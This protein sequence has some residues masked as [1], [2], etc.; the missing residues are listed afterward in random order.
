M[1]RE[2]KGIGT[3]GIVAIIAI[4]VILAGFFY[5]VWSTKENKK[6]ISKENYRETNTERNLNFEK[7]FEDSNGNTEKGRNR[8]S[9]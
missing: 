9:Y 2:S 4:L 3:V 6:T 7:N 5:Y 1:D 8:E